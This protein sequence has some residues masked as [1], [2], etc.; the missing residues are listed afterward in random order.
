[1]KRLIHTS[2]FFAGLLILQACNRN[3]FVQLTFDVSTSKSSYQVG[4]NIG[5]NF[6]G[7]PYLITFYSGELGKR[8]EN[9]NRFTAQGT[10]KLHFTSLIANGAQTGSLH[11]MVSSDF[12]GVVKGNDSIT[13]S[14]IPKASWNDI[15]SRATLSSGTSTASGAIDLSNFAAL[16]KPVYIAF[17]YTAE[18]GSIQ[19]KWTI[20]GLTVT[21]TLPDATTYTLANLT[22]TAITNY[23]NSYLFSPGWVAYKV[24][25]AFNWVVTSGSSLVITG[26]TTAAA[27]TIAAEAWVITGPINLRTVTA[28]LGVPIKNIA[29]RMLSYT[30]KYTT[31]GTYTATFVGSN[32]NVYGGKEDLKQIQLTITP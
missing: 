7:N 5:Y 4:G 1:M 27:A 32:A 25:N 30:N 3:E 24:S 13:I 8:Y 9:R 12:L 21:N 15:T 14:N 29:T 19:R 18:S 26:A 22:S 16:E 17:K 31:A 23:G 20:T 2:I 6:T 11:I 10:P 28:D